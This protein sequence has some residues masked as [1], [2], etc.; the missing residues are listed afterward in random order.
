MDPSRDGH[1][2]S[3]PAWA[4]RV[5]RKA[6]DAQVLDAPATGLERWVAGFAEGAVARQLRGQGLGHPLHPLA[7]TVPLGAWLCSAVFDVLPDGRDAARRLIAIGLLAAPAAMVPGLAD[8]SGLNVR[9][10]RVG[11]VHAAANAAATALFGASYLARRGGHDGRLLG[12]LG[13]AVT[14][15]GGALGGHLTYA[16]GAG[17]FRWEP[18]DDLAPAELAGEDPAAPRNPA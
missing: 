9:Q 16:Q 6:E 1:A 11:L 13:L 18:L 7:V 14:S 10:R 8:Y 12:A 2:R 3:K 4:H 15:V 17:V 5:L